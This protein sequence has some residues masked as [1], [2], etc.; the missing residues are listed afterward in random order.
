MDCPLN[1]DRITLAGLFME[2]HAGVQAELE[3]RLESECGLSVQWFEVLLRL[4]RSPDQRLRMQELT[5]QVTL[6]PSGLTRAVDRLEKEGLVRRESCPS[7]RRGAFAVL[8]A[9]G[10]RRIDKAVPIHIDH[11]D[12]CFTGILNAKERTALE[13]AL[14]KLRDATN[15]CAAITSASTK[16]C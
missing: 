4:A 7:D 9:A 2:A 12:Q 13:S 15:P 5:A 10:K 1:D 3:R 16:L 8:T 14:R 6:T 11:L